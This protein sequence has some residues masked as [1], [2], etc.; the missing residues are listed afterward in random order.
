MDLKYEIYPVKKSGL[1]ELPVKVIIPRRGN[2][3]NLLELTYLLT[4]TFFL[5]IVAN[6]P[7]QIGLLALNPMFLP[8]GFFVMA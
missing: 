2:R 6:I 7:G 4:T 1:L 8:Q 5:F 3:Q